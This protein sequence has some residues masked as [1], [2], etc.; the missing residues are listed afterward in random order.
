MPTANPAHALVDIRKNIA[1]LKSR[2]KTLLNNLKRHP[3]PPASPEVYNRLVTLTELRAIAKS[4]GHLPRDAGRMLNLLINYSALAWMPLRLRHPPYRDKRTP[5]IHLGI[6]AHPQ[7]T[8]PYCYRWENYSR[9][10]YYNKGRMTY[11][12]GF[13]NAEG[14]GE[15]TWKLFVLTLRALGVEPGSTPEGWMPLDVQIKTP[16]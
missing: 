6:L 7:F 13:R 8:S 3:L 15:T 10:P 14:V 16:A 1:S 5:C 9:S 11:P 2:E 12:E 4:L